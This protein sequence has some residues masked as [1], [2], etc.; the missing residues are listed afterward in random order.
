ML[1]IKFIKENKELVEK[2]AKQKKVEVSIEKL[3]LLHKEKNTLQQSLD[4]KRSESS[5]LTKGIQNAS[6]TEKKKLLKT[7]STQKIEITKI[8]GKHRKIEEEYQLLLSLIP[9][10]PTKDTPVGKDDSENVVIKTVGEKTKLGFTPRHH[11]DLGVSLNILDKEKAAKVSGARFAYIKS[12]LALLEFAIIQFVFSIVTNEKT[13]AKIFKS[14]GLKI[15]P[16]PFIPVLPPVFV[17]SSV[18]TAMGRLEPREDKYELSEDDQFLIGSAEHTLGPIHMGE[19]IH[20]EDLPIRYIGFSTCF[21][22]EAGTYG[23]D[24]KGMIRMHQ[25]DKLEMETFTTSENGLEEQKAL[26]AIQE[27]IM[28]ELAIPYQVVSICTGDMGKPDA[29][30]IDIEAWM[31]GLNR[32]LETHS[33]DYI[34]DFQSRR[35]KTFVKRENG[36]EL[37]Y[38]NDAT[39][40]AFSRILAAIIENFQTKKGTVTIPKVLRPCMF[41][42]KEISNE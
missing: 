4:T 25:F 15:S 1:D 41:G 39:A 14:A 21:R 42:K 12:D 24:M 13:L 2:A 8:Q 10:I 33:A 30:Q 17:R 16:K 5:A 23:K 20:E 22:R 28:N 40:V 35:L 31:P 37:V 11:E 6:E 3:L 26:V 32:Y 27:Y 36:K 18:F 9:N 34:T 29:K 7:A 38:M 19:T